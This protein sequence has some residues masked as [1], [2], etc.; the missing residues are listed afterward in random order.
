MKN[1]ILRCHF[2]EE[3]NMSN[4]LM[5]KTQN[6]IDVKTLTDEG[7]EFLKRKLFSGNSKPANDDFLYFL[8]IAKQYGFNP[9]L[10]EIYLLPFKGG[11]WS[12]YVSAR[13]LE[14]IA[15]EHPD[16]D[17]M[18]SGVELGRDGIPLKGWCKIYRKSWTRPL[19]VEV[20]F[21]EYYKPPTKDGTYN[22]WDEKPCEMIEKVA[23]VK[24][25]RKAFGEA[26]NLYA[27]EEMD[28]IENPIKNLNNPPQKTDTK[29]EPPKQ[30]PLQKISPRKAYF[31]ELCKTHGKEAV[32]RICV[33]F[34]L[35]SDYKIEDLQKVEATLISMLEASGIS[36]TVTEEETIS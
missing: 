32:K 13:G 28:I 11:K 21:K 18:E 5:F 29:Q 30:K 27:E 10:N 8:S 22:I 2:K 7:I 6:L 9:F 35:G 3:K 36:N 15:R 24:A 31:E 19:S 25:I 4:D 33:D 16:F 23:I 14:K 12:T 26:A 1:Q 20:F 34:G 17:G